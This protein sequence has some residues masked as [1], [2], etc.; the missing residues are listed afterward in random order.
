MLSAAMQQ[1]LAEA[2][3]RLVADS[4]AT[5]P[6]FATVTA[7]QVAEATQL[8]RE[9]TARCP[10]LPWDVLHEALGPILPWQFWV[11]G[12]STGN[13]KSTFLMS[14]VAQWLTE[15]RRL[16]MLPLEQP[17]EVMRLV[18][19]ALRH[20]FDP[21][22]VLSGQWERLLP[23]ARARVQADL[24]WQ[25]TPEAASLLHFSPRTF[26]DEAALRATWNEAK[27]FGAEVVI[28]DHLHRLQM[29]GHKDGYQSLVRMAQL[30]KE[31]AKETRIPA[32]VAAQLHRGDGDSLAPYRPPKPTSIQGGEVV[33][34][35][36]DVAV[37]LFRPLLHALTRE[38]EQAIRTG[39]KPIQHFLA[40]N[41]VGV[42]VLKHRVDGAQ[43]GAVLKLGWERGMLRDPSTDQRLA[44]EARHD[45]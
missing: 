7:Q 23:E 44:W 36:C 10:R 25:A 40:P 8:T 5:A 19:A 11:V 6:D 30:I 15:G 32:L 17:G 28:I 3:L 29:T 31:L 18:L 2:P 16:F 4:G 34:Q 24:R 27:A 45:L 1:A 12:A 21:R 33:R 43:T 37:G 20:G 9:D 14:L 39:T 26:V 35:E 22:H 13:G 41:C 38:D 42:H